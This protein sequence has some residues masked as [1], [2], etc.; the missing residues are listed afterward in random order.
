LSTSQKVTK[1]ENI[2]KLINNTEN[3]LTQE[4]K[5]L[6]E[7]RK[8]LLEIDDYIDSEFFEETE[9][10]KKIKIQELRR[11]LIS[12][13]K[14]LDTQQGNN[15]NGNSIETPNQTGEITGTDYSKTQNGNVF[16]ASDPFAIEYMEEAEK[17]FYS[18][19]YTE[20]LKNYDKVLQFEPNWE[21]AKQHREESENYLRTGYIPPIALPS[22]AASSFGK[23]QSASRAGRYEDAMNYI[24]KA[25]D[26]LANYGIHRW[27]EGL[28]F[29]QKLQENIDAEKTYQD[30]ISLFELGKIDEALER[31]ETASRM[32][33]LPKY[34]EKAQQL[35][36]LKR[37]IQSILESLSGLEID[38]KV[39]AKAKSKLDLLFS[40]FGDNPALLRI[41]P[42]LKSTLPR[43]VTPLKDSA[44]SLYTQAERAVEIDEGLYLANQAKSSIDQI[45]ILDEHNENIDRIKIDIEK[46]IAKFERYQDE[47][48]QAFSSFENNR[49]WPSQAARMS[50]EIRQRF[51]DDP[52]IRRLR[53]ALTPYYSSQIIIKLIGF[54]FIALLVIAIG[55]WTKGKYSTYLLSLTP[56]ITATPT[57]TATFTPSPTNT[58]TQTP[59]PSPT[60]TSTPTS[61]PIIGMTLRDVW[62]RNGCYEGFTATGRIPLGSTLE[63]L[64]MER[65]FDNFNRECVLVEFQNKGNPIIGWILLLDVG[66][67]P[68]DVEN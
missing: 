40:E 43:A 57:F 62:A 29:E 4:F 11:Q 50:Q 46:L 9:K 20:A 26:V 34:S 22:E 66:N 24:Q 5:S 23:A 12:K 6:V 52:Q 60:I 21:R 37:T 2:D 3:Y 31:I 45:L 30:G 28:E 19:R 56:T 44:N 36:D 39:V 42:Q 25:K 27:Q 17:F 1:L 67:P 54:L 63:F 61:T 49:R 18:G 51:P 59:S 47:L 35:Y 65:R 41:K 48:N 64:P 14:E 8:M 58:T 16:Q 53:K 15:A 32:T 7:L 55:W 68:E 10:Q 38:P 13:I 33:G